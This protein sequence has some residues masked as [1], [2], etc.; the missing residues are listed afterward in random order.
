MPSFR[1]AKDQAAH[2]IKQ[3][4]GKKNFIK[5][6]GTARNYEDRLIQIAKF[7]K[8]NKHNPDFKNKSLKDL[9]TSLAQKVLAEQAKKVGQKTLDMDRQAMQSV[10]QNITHDLKSNER[11]LDQTGHIHLSEKPQEL[12]PRS[13]TSE[14]VEL[15]KN[16]QNE[17]NAFSTEL[18]Y[19]SGL[20]AVELQTLQPLN[21]RSPSDRPANTEKFSGLDGK[22]YT[23]AGKGGLVRVVCIPTKLAEKLESYRLSEPK[24]IK[25]RRAYILQHYNIGGGQRWSSSFSRAS[26]KALGWSNGGHG[27]RHSYTQERYK[28]L[29]EYCSNDKVLETTSQELGH[30]RPAITKVYLR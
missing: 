2:L 19:R 6:V 13:Y 1:N 15:I 22:L 20:R 3:L 7:L 5:G 23:V 21:E 24:Q 17:A 8:K 12:K 18:A 14:Q 30:F 11:L 16:H 9:D 28:K 4:Q 29:G 27:L 26:N 10:L 25:D